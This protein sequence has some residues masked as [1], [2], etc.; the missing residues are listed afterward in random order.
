M[1]IKGTVKLTGEILAG[2]LQSLF[3]IV[4]EMAYSENKSKIFANLKTDPHKNILTF[5]TTSDEKS[6]RELFSQAFLKMGQTQL[7]K[8]IDEHTAVRRALGYSI[9]TGEAPKAAHS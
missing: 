7:C 3:T 5:D 8:G 4:S 6:A 9:T 2:D 1:A